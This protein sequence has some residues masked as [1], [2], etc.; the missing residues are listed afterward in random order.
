MGAA[1]SSQPSQ[2]SN[3]FYFN[4]IDPAFRDNP[5]AHY[6]A[7]LAGPPRKFN[8]FIP[9]T[10]VAR[11]DDC[12]A[13]LRDH[14]HFS[15]RPPAMLQQLRAEF[16]PFAGAT[17][18]LDSDPPVHTRLRRLVSRAFTP[19]RIK[20][21]EPRIRAI[22]A[23]LLDRI[24]RAERFD[25]MEDLASPLPMIVIAEMLGVPPEEHAQ[26]KA[27]SNSII[28]GGRGTLRGVAP[29][30]KV[31]SNSQELRAYL[32]EQIELRRREPGADLITALVQAHD[33]GG[34]LSAEELLA[35]VVLL[36]LA[37]NETTTNLIGNGTL[38]LMRRP[39]QLLRLR[40]D[41]AMMPH[42]IDEMLRFDGPVQATVRNCTTAT[43][44]GGTEIAVGELVFVILAAAN[45]DPAKFADGNTFDIAR[46]ANEHIAFG[47]GIHF[48]LGA[49]LARMEG[50]IALA[51]MLERFPNLRLASPD[52]ALEYRGSY[53]LRGLKSLPM[54]AG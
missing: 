21:L 35:F 50:E 39:D 33:E 40:G 18:M 52:A 28:E 6:P 13:V 45:R 49:S 32:G 8:V 42:A 5:Y 46:T 54:I 4:P 14:E 31:K 20:D 44:I 43:N 25:L 12:L 34:S 41:L 47:E 24:A 23:E 51:A 15:S 3:D 27:W 17:T 36:L 11:Y 7:L 19:R 10:L 26:F 38:A 1:A 48:C 53:L 30:D 2:G 29:G 37:G 16:G 22:A 9:T